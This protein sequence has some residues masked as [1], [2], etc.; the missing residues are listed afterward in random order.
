MTGS[1]FQLLLKATLLVLISSVM[2]CSDPK[3]PSEKNFEKAIN[4][5]IKESV[6]CFNDEVVGGTGSGWT[7]NFFKF[8]LRF[9]PNPATGMIEG[10]RAIGHLDAFVEAGLLAASEEIV[11]Q[12]R[13][14][15]DRKQVSVR[16]YDLTDVGR[17]SYRGDGS[18]SFCY[19]IGVVDE[20]TNFTLPAAAGPQQMVTVQYTYR[21]EDLADWTEHDYF[22]SL[23]ENAEA[24]ED[25]PIKGTAMLTLTNNGW[26]PYGASLG[27]LGL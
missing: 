16:V 18:G 19:G 14:Q 4:E 13:G 3:D 26:V 24:S 12:N 1:S 20:I 15:W 23:R 25:T 21:I 8:P 9:V 27:L 17:E 2:A 5:A 10:K 22:S 7:Q 6:A 11:E